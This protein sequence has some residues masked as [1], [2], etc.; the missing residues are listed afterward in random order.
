MKYFSGLFLMFLCILSC[1]KT[2]ENVEVVQQLKPWHSAGKK[3]I[4]TYYTTAYMTSRTPRE[5]VSI[6]TDWTFNYFPEEVLNEDFIYKDFN[7][8]KWSAIAI[9]HTWQGYETTQQEHPFIMNAAEE[10]KSFFGKK[11]GVGNLKYW[12]YGWGCYQKTF[13]IKQALNG[14]RIFIEFEAVMKYSKVYLNGK[15]LG[16]HK[17]GFNAF[18]FDITDKVLIGKENKLSVAV[19]NRLNDRFKIPPMQSGNQTHSGGIYRD[20]NLVI[21]NG[22]YI[23]FQGSYKH[24]GGTFVQTPK[25][26]KENAEVTVKTYITNKSGQNK[27]VKLITKIESPERKIISKLV[28][29]KNIQK[30]SLVEFYQAF[31]TIKNPKFWSPEKPTLYKVISEVWIDDKLSDVYESPLGFRTFSW[32]K[33]EN[34][35]V[36]NGEKIHIHGTN[37]TQCFPWVNNAIPDW[38]NIMDVKDIKYGQGHNFIRPNL[39]SVNPIMHDMF[40]QF[41]I[42][43][44]LANPNIKPLDFNED[45]Q[46]QIAIASVRKHRNRPSIV[47]YEVGNETNDGVDSKWIYQEDATRIIT[48]RHVHGGEG[49]FI[50]HDDT[51]MDM[52]N[53][54]RCTVRGW[55]DNSVYSENPEN[56]QHTGNE[57]FQHAMAR[58]DGGSQRGR[59]DMPNGNMWMYSDDGAIRV[60]KNAPLNYVNP[61]GWVDVYRVPKYLYFLWQAHYYKK[62][63]AFIHPH[64]WQEK[65]V[66]TKQNIIIDS[67]CDTV[68]L[69]VDNVSYGTQKLNKKNF[70]TVTFNNI[71]VKKGVLK[72]VGT[73]A[74]KNIVRVLPMASKPKSL[75]LT[76]SPNEMGASRDHIAML[77]VDVRDENG[78]QV[79]AF[80][81][82]LKWS[83][84]GEGKFIAPELWQTDINKRN[85]NSGVWYMAT[86]VSNF[87]R[88][89]GTAGEITVKVESEGVES[90]EIKIIIKA[91]KLKASDFISQ[92][93]LSNNGR[94]A[95]IWEPAFKTSN[96]ALN[97]I[98][99]A[100][101]FVDFQLKV[102]DKPHVYQSYFKSYILDKNPILKQHPEVT[103]LIV[104]YFADHVSKKRGLLVNDD[105]NFIVDNVNRYLK[106]LSEHKN[107]S[108]K[109]KGKLISKLTPEN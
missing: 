107:I 14:K 34:V 50:T 1:N 8:S 99:M 28:Q 32:D 48:K 6:N 24:E 81:K 38:V 11:G 106:Y 108:A 102:N 29:D 2:H 16:D 68:E 23:P 94:E 39:H 15:L 42:M 65:Y 55:T 17:G 35:G 5:V 75:V 54:L 36:L 100:Y 7:D 109:E 53:L 20:V 67:N 51:N 63:M 83:I 10:D 56:N 72:V 95:V 87:V 105:Y 73:K 78:V 88:A 61:K 70:Y 80:N 101:A 52:E 27:T 13:K 19:N 82:D 71:P 91:E 40:D 31:K 22:V 62:P 92:P 58:V 89:S 64:F 25:I 9:P 45:V 4:D 41:G 103:K 97:Y 26:T 96:E 77:T 3:Q 43:V 46:K 84:K 79:Q 60:Y 49:D 33:T 93:K 98:P 44:N 86:P 12:Y 47:M 30:D 85:A 18:Y 74:G 90:A 76:R 66:G 59:I 104:S 21:K 57:E 37:R 69:F